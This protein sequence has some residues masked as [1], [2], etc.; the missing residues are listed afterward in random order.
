MGP[1]F[2]TPALA[3]VQLDRLL[4]SSPTIQRFIPREE[5]LPEG[6]IGPYMGAGRGNKS[7]ALTKLDIFFC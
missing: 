6:D 7:F 1:S 5:K 3:S 2:I 4:L